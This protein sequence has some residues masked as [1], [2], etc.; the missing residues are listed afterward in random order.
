MAVGGKKTNEGT[1]GLSG[2][3]D[4]LLRSG[5]NRSRKNRKG[6][7]TDGTGN[8]FAFDNTLRGLYMIVVVRSKPS[9]DNTHP[10]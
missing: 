2:I 7:A 8:G 5:K 10:C 1:R 3:P 4:W 6:Y 9:I